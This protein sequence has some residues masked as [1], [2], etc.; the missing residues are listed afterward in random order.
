MRS[1]RSEQIS[2][3][4]IMRITDMRPRA[5]CRPARNGKQLLHHAR[6]RCAQARAAHPCRIAADDRPRLSRRATGPT[7]ASE[8]E[9][10]TYKEVRCAALSLENRARQTPNFARASQMTAAASP[11]PLSVPPPRRRARNAR[12]QLRAR[13]SDDNAHALHNG[14]RKRDGEREKMRE[15]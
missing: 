14:E 10:V 12:C 15:R 3:T 11:L 5:G 9:V 4:F 7:T 6:H 2:K 8:R 13:S 1:G